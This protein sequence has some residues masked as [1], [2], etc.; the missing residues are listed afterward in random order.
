MADNDT[1]DSH[2]TTEDAHAP[3]THEAEE[4]TTPEASDAA[5]E[6]PTGEPSAEEAV[7]EEAA[8]EPEDVSNGTGVFLR[9]EPEEEALYA[10]FDPEYAKAALDSDALKELI[11]KAGHA[12][13]CLFREVVSQLIR[14]QRDSRQ[15]FSL[16]IGGHRD[17]EVEIT[18]DPKG[19]H[20]EARLTHPC[21]NGRA[22]DEAMI[23]EALAEAGVTHGIRESEFPRI[24]RDQG[25]TLTDPLLIAQGTQ[26]TNGEDSRFVS[27]IPDAVERKPRVLNEDV[28]D[29]RDFG[30]II[31]VHE[32]DELVRRDPPTEGTDGHT[33]TGETIPAQPGKTRD[34]KLD[35]TVQL[36]EDD[37]DVLIAA[38]SGM[39][40]IT[41]QG[42]KVEQTLELEN[43]D[44]NIGHV[45]FDGTI[46]VKGDIIAGMRVTASGDINVGGTVEAATL[47]ADGNITVNGGILGHGNVRDESGELRKES[48]MV[49]SG[50]T[51][52]ARFIKNILV[53]AQ[54]SVIAR[55]LIN[56]SEVTSYNQVLV[57]G[58]GGPAKAQIVGGLVRA[59]TK[60]ESAILGSP[61]ATHTR[62]EV[63]FDPEFHERHKAARQAIIDKQKMLADVQR[64]VNFYRGSPE[65]ARAAEKA[66]PGVLQKLV[67]TER[68]ARADL[69]QLQANLDALE[70]DLDHI[71]K[72][73]V[74]AKRQ[75]Y[76]NVT[77]IFGPK[78]RTTDEDLEGGSFA[79]HDQWITFR[80]GKT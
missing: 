8:A 5:P 27:L 58:K 21:G 52:T 46:T 78:S 68:Q 34:F 71:R 39:P 35:K 57:G 42:A 64:M 49:T 38:I 37:P 43:I 32:G 70:E 31:T 76:S 77:I 30:G 44:L 53:E 67:K 33:V 63:G 40:V 79:L 17:G 65:K 29:Y 14:Q 75:V 11:T 73:R 60:I 25:R 51:V 4:A 24:I 59:T 19:T 48:G 66:K 45:D 12:D 62:V 69:Q 22:I 36:K 28:V 72:A 50:C 54:D 61:R 55:D 18:V 47:R 10:D 7:E 74:V 13:V 1:N 20:A 56:N 16:A 26:P 41:D 6:A 9:W 3:E 15:S 23:R 2:T 80:K